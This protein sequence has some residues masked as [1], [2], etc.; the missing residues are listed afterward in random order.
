MLDYLIYRGGELPPL[1]SALRYIL[2]GNGLLLQAHRQH[3]KALVLLATYPVKGLPPLEPYLTTT[4]PKVSQA[5]MSQM[6][7]TARNQQD[8]TGHPLEIVF[9]FL[10]EEGEWQLIIPE[11]EQSY[12]HCRPVN[13]GEASYRQ[14]VLEIHS[15]HH[16]PAY[17]SETDDQ[18]EQG[19]FRF[20]GVVGHFLDKPRLRLR[21]GIYGHFISL[22]AE[23][24][25]ALPE[26]VECALTGEWGECAIN[27]ESAEST[28]AL[29]A[30][31]PNKNHHSY[32]TLTQGWRKLLKTHKIQKIPS[33]PHADKLNKRQEKGITPQKTG[34]NDHAL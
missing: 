13:S 17:F 31:L 16:F 21:L 10:L 9:H 24:L 11:Q 25:L 27:E 34:G 22:P 33:R 6:L 12:T 14:A 18:D 28:G 8:E 20:L 1:N 2:A 7:E 15:H 23:L 3:I 5:L 4:L 19:V 29:L 30:T 26:E 32:S